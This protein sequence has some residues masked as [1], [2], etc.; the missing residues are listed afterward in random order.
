MSSKKTKLLE[1]AQKNFLK[2]QYARAVAE[3]RQLIELEPNDMRHRQKIA[4][5]LTKANQKDEAIK[6]YTSLAKHYV[7]LVHY[8]KAIAVYKQIQKLEP[9][10][11]ET[12]LT[13]ASLNEKQGL[14]GNAIAE[15]ATAVQIYESRGENLKALKAL[16]SIMAL[17]SGNSSVK[18]R[19]A[20]KYFSTGAEESS[21]NTFASLLTDLKDRND[22]TGF[23][24]IA[25]RALNL[26]GDKAK[27]LLDRKNEDEVS[28]ALHIETAPPATV[29]LTTE[30]PETRCNEPESQLTAPQ[31]ATAN[32]PES[33]ETEIYEE[34]DYIEDILPLD[35]TGLS[36]QHNIDESGH[37]WEE[38]IELVSFAPEDDGQNE[39]AEILEELAA[40]DELFELELELEIED[41]PLPEATAAASLQAFQ[42]D[43][44]FDLGKDLAIFA[45]A[46]DFDLLGSEND[47]TTF[48]ISSSGFKKSELDNED[49]E[50]HYSLGLAYKE[51]GLFDEAI[52]EFIIAARSRERKIDSS[53]LQGVCLR[54]VGSVDKAVEIL[55]DTL[56]HAEITEDE[57]LGIQYEIALCYEVSENFT[58]A[59]SILADIL[60]ARPAFNDVATRL[61]NL[62]A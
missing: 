44:S 37:E 35:D 7:D 46:I 11:P 17:D 34:I 16:E 48:D 2:G 26:F 45:D 40:D 60:K 10:N 24:M 52:G 8:L 53:I 57:R 25:E 22:E 12:T 21:F 42:D 13:L 54:E 47:G 39:N 3:Y 29:E 30:K 18:L 14:I 38:E 49:A 4:E 28:V 20:E 62:P 23:K 6:E 36:Q 27:D 59:R 55:T 9:A 41:E 43:D 19:I 33:V 56:E 32:G 31:P 61:K 50:S 1:S 58:G 15:Y 5:I 51:M